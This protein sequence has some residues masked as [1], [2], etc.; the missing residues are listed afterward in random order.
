MGGW[1]PLTR[2]VSSTLL[3]DSL[4]QVSCVMDPTCSLRVGWYI[5]VVDRGPVLIL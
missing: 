1:D 4:V 5:L 3:C 2:I